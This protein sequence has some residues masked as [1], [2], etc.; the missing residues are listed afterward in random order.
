MG[1][2][3]RYLNELY[4]VADK[5]DAASCKR[6]EEIGQLLRS[7][8]TDSKDAEA[9]IERKV[10]EAEAAVGALRAEMDADKYRMLPLSVIAKDYFGK[11]AAWLS[12]RLNGTPVRGRV[13]TLNAEQKDIF[14]MAVQDIA[15]KIGSLHLA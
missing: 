12:Q 13:Y 7:S 15:R 10:A 8:E 3:E 1:E 6:A 5:R 11:S 2:R 9:F 4:E 14:N